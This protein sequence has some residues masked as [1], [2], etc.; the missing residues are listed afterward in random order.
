[1]FSKYIF[2]INIASFK[3]LTP[4]LGTIQ[5]LPKTRRGWVGVIQMLFLSY[6]GVRAYVTGR[7]GG[8][9]WTKIAN[10]GFTPFFFKIY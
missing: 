10:F 8:G 2:E 1:M 9:S 5:L 4:I 3:H 6:R 7:G